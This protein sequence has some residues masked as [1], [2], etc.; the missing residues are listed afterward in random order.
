MWSSTTP[1]YTYFPM[2]EQFIKQQMIQHQ[3]FVLDD[4]HTSYPFQYF[5]E[6]YLKSI[7]L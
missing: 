1:I 6:K 2:F 5:L 3:I 7:V 4:L